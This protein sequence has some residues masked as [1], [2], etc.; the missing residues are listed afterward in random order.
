MSQQI[1]HHRGK[2]STK[3][4][5][6]KKHAS[7][8]KGG[9]GPT[10]SLSDSISVRVGGVSERKSNRSSASPSKSKSKRGGLDIRRSVKIVNKNPNAD[11]VRVYEVTEKGLFSSTVV[12]VNRALGDP[13]LVQGG[14]TKVDYSYS[15]T[16]N[17][18]PT[19]TIRVYWRPA[20]HPDDPAE[21]ERLLPTAGPIG[22]NTLNKR[23]RI[24]IT[25]VDIR[26]GGETTVIRLRTPANYRPKTG[27][28][29]KKSKR[30]ASRSRSRS[31]SRRKSTRKR[32][33][34]QKTAAAQ[35]AALAKIM[36]AYAKATGK[37]R[38][39]GVT[40]KSKRGTSRSRS[41]SHKSRTTAQK[42]AAVKKTALA[43]MRAYAKA[44]ATTRMGGATRKHVHHSRARSHT[45][46]TS[47]A[48]RDSQG[49]FVARV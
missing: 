25:N 11:W 6:H 34:A 17:F 3:S 43:I 10:R 41:R 35:K 21:G 45:H 38:S 37:T 8:R 23:I 27:G 16:G 48:T 24:G 2:V 22:L 42:A 12:S 39:G 5:K 31:I 18:T 49:R 32:T 29:T 4:H 1:K 20:Q 28:V 15:M 40:K 33:T 44:M 19:H 30:G 46:S 36:R 47:T 14:N 7:T 26:E 9:R 13:L